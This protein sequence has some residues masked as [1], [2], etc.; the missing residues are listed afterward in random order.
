M[1]WMCVLVDV[2]PEDDLGFGY[3]G[4]RR[5]IRSDQGDLEKKRDS[6][7]LDLFTFLFFLS[8]FLFVSSLVTISSF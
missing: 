5:V 2:L 1:G 6:G 3:W 8:S 7:Q 4:K